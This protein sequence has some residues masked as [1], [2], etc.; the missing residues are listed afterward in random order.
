MTNSWR[1]P[2]LG[3]PKLLKEEGTIGDYT[4]AI[5]SATLK[6]RCKG[7]IISYKLLH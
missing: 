4:S 6:I 5:R 1:T 7:R 3:C 2:R